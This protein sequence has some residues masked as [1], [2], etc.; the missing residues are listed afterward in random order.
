M[1]TID[2]LITNSNKFQQL[3]K[4]CATTTM[5]S[6]TGITN[7]VVNYENPSLVDKFLKSCFPRLK[8]LYRST[9]NIDAVELQAGQPGRG[10]ASFYIDSLIFGTCEMEEDAQGMGLAVEPKRDIQTGARKRK[11]DGFVS[12]PEVKDNQAKDVLLVIRNIDYCMDFC[13][14]SPG[15]IDARALDIFD[16]FRDPNIKRKCRILLVSNVPLKFP[17]KTRVVS[18]AP[19]DEY[20][21]EHILNSFVL[22]YKQ[23]EYKIEFTDKQKEQ[24][25]R[26]LCGLTYSE[27]SDALLQS[28]S[29]KSETEAGSKE[30]D[31]LKVIRSLR[32]N[33]NDNF[34]SKAVGVTSLES[35]YKIY[36]FYSILFA[37]MT[38]RFN[39]FSNGIFSLL[40]MTK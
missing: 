3:S 9:Y 20:E 40:N 31:P 15:E 14:E 22:L 4:E 8:E 19:V 34:M 1:K 2:E 16:K 18:F 11:S 37:N 26:K 28:L 32:K 17:F 35:T 27:A 6:I 33:I 39:Y 10:N 12:R 25:K 5:Y 21:A 29:S 38:N 36:V 23:S 24:I 7:L 13:K 30:I